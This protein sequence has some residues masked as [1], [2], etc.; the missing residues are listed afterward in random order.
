MKN[1]FEKSLGPFSFPLCFPHP[2]SCVPAAPL[3]DPGAC[4]DPGSSRRAAAAATWP[5][6]VLSRFVRECVKVG[7]PPNPEL[8]KLEPELILVR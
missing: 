1:A 5:G 6:F 2:L 8:L 3:R 4:L 7:P